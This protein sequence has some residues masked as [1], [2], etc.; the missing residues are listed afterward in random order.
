[1]ELK[2]F[3]V[4][5]IATFINGLANLLNNN[6][7]NPPHWIILE[8][9][10]LESFKS[11]DILLLNVFLN[12]GFCFVVSNNSC[13]KLFQSSIFKFILRVVPVFF[14]DNIFHFFSCVPDNL[15]FIYCPQPL[16]CNYNTFAVPLE[17][18]RVVSFDIF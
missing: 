2:H 8:I 1:M 12:F 7:R 5:G 14:F 10:A 3:F 18:Y 16:I 17:N 13:G 11:V 6:P 4:K 9:C 15:R